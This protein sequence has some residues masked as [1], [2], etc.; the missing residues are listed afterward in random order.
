VLSCRVA[1]IRFP[2]VIASYAVRRSA[3][4]WRVFASAVQITF[5]LPFWRVAILHA[6]PV[7]DRLRVRGIDDDEGRRLG[8]H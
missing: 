6:G 8:R 3:G 5:A 2:A 1:N 7:A 4:K